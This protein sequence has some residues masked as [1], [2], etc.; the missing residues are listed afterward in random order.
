MAL[1]AIVYLVALL[2]RQSWPVTM[3]FPL[4][5]L[6]YG[7]QRFVWEFLKPYGGLPFDLSVFHII[8]LLLVVY[9]LLLLRGTRHA[10]VGA[11]GN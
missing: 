1:F 9:A 4:V 11:V 8:S 6:W 3:G 10:A 5:V 2:R 7:L